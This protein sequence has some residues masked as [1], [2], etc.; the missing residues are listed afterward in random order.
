[1]D[2]FTQ[3][4]PNIE[5]ISPICSAKTIYLYTARCDAATQVE[6]KVEEIRDKTVQAIY[7]K[8]EEAVET[9]KSTIEANKASVHRKIEE[10]KLAVEEATET[11][12]SYPSKLKLAAKEAIKNELEVVYVKIFNTWEERI[13]AVNNEIE[14]RKQEILSIK[15]GIVCECQNTINSARRSILEAVE[16]KIEGGKKYVF[17]KFEA[18]SG[19]PREAMPVANDLS[20]VSSSLTCSIRWMTSLG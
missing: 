18:V 3:H 10:T 17:C 2:R 5:I 16:S 15:N 20:K 11:V 1:M 9:S 4:M 19:S 6:N 7:S 14:H 12:L 13:K 8:L